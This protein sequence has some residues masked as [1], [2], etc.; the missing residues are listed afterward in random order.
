[1]LYRDAEIACLKAQLTGTEQACAEAQ[2]DAQYAQLQDDFAFIAK[3]NIGGEFL[4]DETILRLEQIGQRTW[5]RHFDN[6][7]G[8]SLLEQSLYHHP[9]PPLPV[10]ERLLADKPEHIVAWDENYKPH[11]ERDDP[12][13]MHGFD[14]QLPHYQRNTGKFIILVFAEG[15]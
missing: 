15:H 13:N 4:S 2:R 8:L 3:C 10:Q 7:L 11:V 12:L 9:A 5:L 6:R 1:M 14:M